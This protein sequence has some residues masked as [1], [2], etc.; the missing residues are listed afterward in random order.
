MSQELLFPQPLELA[1]ARLRAL[2][3]VQP[4]LER[5]GFA[6]EGFGGGALLLRGVPSLLRADDLPRLADELAQELD[7]DAGQGSSPVLERL[8]AFV[9]CRAAIKAHQA[10]APEEMAQVLTDLAETATPYYCP[11]GRPIVSRIPLGEIKRELRR[12]W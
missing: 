12:T 3:R 11:H 1:P 10:L 5:L 9:A 8:L 6:L 7:E 4:Q 2:E